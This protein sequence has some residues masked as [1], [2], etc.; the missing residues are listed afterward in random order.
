MKKMFIYDVAGYTFEDTEAFGKA[1]KAAKEKAA[2]LH[3]AIYRTVRKS[4]TERREVYYKA[5]CFNDV[6]YAGIHEVMIF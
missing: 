1:W 5:G 3:C 4:E 6:K 2:A